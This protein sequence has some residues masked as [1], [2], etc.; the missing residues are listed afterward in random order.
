MKFGAVL[1]AT[2]AAY[3]TEWEEFQAANGARNGDIPE[4]FKA[5]VDYVKK[6]N[7]EH[8]NAKLSYTGPFAAM[9]KAE[10]KEM[11]GF[12]PASSSL[13]GDLPKLGSHEMSGNSAPASMDWDDQGMTT[14]PKNQGHAQSCWSFSSTGALEGAWAIASGKL[15]SL[16]EQQL[17]DCNDNGA[18]SASAGGLMTKAYDWYSKGGSVAS[19]ESYPYTGTDGSCSTDYTEVIPQGGVTGY[20]TVTS[21]DAL[22]DAVANVGPVAVAIEA[23]EQAFQLYES[24]VLVD[25]CG[26]A[27]DHGVTVTGYGTMDGTDY[28]K[29]KNSWGESWGMKGYILIQR[30]VGKC[31]ITEHPFAGSEACY[32]TVSASLQV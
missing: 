4:A 11:L 20:K 29:I 17:I 21:E 23:D 14:P 26:D 31:G 15:E 9:S 18:G 8:E 25:E 7:A 10:Y 28:W 32:P 2:V 30:G 19:E 22:L 5:N 1:I 3:S 12:K 27:L 6:F 16:S 13:M 24:G